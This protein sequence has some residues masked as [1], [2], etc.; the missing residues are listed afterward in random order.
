MV[1]NRRPR[2]GIAACCLLLLLLPAVATS[3]WHDRGYVTTSG[4]RVH[5]IDPSGGVRSTL[6]APS[7]ADIADLIMDADNCQVLLVLRDRQRIVRFD[8]VT[9]AI[10]G[11]LHEGAPLSSP[12]G[13]AIDHNG[14]HYIADA[15]Q[16]AVYR[17]TP[18]GIEKVLSSTTHLDWPEGGVRIDPDTGDLLVLNTS[19]TS[20][21]LYRILR[22]GSGIEP[23]GA[24]FQARYG[25][26]V[27]LPSW[28]IFATSCCQPFVSP[29]RILRLG[30]NAAED[31]F[32]QPPGLDGAY[33]V[34]CDRSSA[35]DQRLVVAPMFDQAGIWFIDMTS[36][37]VTSLQRLDRPQ[38]ALEFVH[39]RNVQPVAAGSGRWD[40]RLSFPGEA[41]NSYFVLLSVNG[42][43]PGLLLGDG[44]KI[45]LVLDVVARATL[46]LEFSS[47]FWNN[48][49]VLD[50]AGEAAAHL[51]VRPLGPNVRGLRLWAQAL[52]FHPAAPLGI[53]TIAEPVVLVV[54]DS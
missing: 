8:P 17:L 13:I 39:G 44:R 54:E 23:V 49:G 25:F 26:D 6:L 20:D 34:R 28:D 27:H 3:Q 48:H 18:R 45:Q 43:R 16:Q 36:R 15:T 24:G 53:R 47:I 50:G 1:R 29:I 21:R 42:V 7:H 11:T 46:T 5:V 35:R 2:A 41:R 22:N 37:A 31:F 33:A 10:T 14:H 52:T 9:L 38:L 12:V 32:V 19:V 4:D 40:I 30:Q 51:D